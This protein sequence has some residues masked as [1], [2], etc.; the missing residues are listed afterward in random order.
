[1]P[2]IGF[3]LKKLITDKEGRHVMAVGMIEQLMVS[4]MNVYNPPEEG[5]DLI[6]KVVEMIIYESQGVT[7]AAG[8]FNL[9]MDPSKDTQSV[10]LHSSNQAAKIMRGAVKEIGLTDVWRALHPKRQRLHLLY[11]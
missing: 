11:F 8:D 9:I 4:F 7:I 2:Q 3:T 6:K 1:M 10:R 5:P